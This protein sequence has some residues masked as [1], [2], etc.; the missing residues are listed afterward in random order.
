MTDQAVP[1]YH[2][3]IMAGEVLSL[4]EPSRGGILRTV[5]WAAAAMRRGCWKCCLPEGVFTA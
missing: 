4:L 3:P 5:P 2:A 1:F